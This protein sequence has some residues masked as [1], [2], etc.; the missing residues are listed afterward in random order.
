M[1]RSGTAVERSGRHNGLI[2]PLFAFRPVIR[3]HQDELAGLRGTTCA[4]H[5]TRHVPSTARTEQLL[6]GATSTSRSGNPSSC[7]QANRIDIVKPPRKLPIQPALHRA[8]QWAVER[9]GRHNGL[10]QPLFAFRPGW[11]LPRL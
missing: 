3:S 6:P 5:A 4:W 7:H 1:E 11:S 8:P 2:Q 10:I 9:S